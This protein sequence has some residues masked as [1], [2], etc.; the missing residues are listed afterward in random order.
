MIGL[1]SERPHRRTS[2]RAVDVEHA[3][4]RGEDGVVGD[5][6]AIGTGLP[7]RRDRQKYQRGIDAMELLP[8]ESH[9][10]DLA[11]RE[12]F[13]D[14]IGGARQRE[15]QLASARMRDIERQRALVEIIEPEEQA[16]IVMRQVIVEWADAAPVVA[17]G[18]LDLDDIGAHVGQQSRA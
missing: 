7:E 10:S 9:R 11:G 17:C 13:D 15:Q 5:E 2:G 16:A 8:S 3:G 14:H 4:Q 6:I 12:A 1:Q 18:R